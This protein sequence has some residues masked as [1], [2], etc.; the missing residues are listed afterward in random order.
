MQ[1]CLYVCVCVCVCQISDRT[2]RV[3]TNK[4]HPISFETFLINLPPTH[5]SFLCSLLKQ[6]EFDWNEAEIG[7]VY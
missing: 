3:Y 6:F 7:L 4:Y 2:R 1:V 5:L